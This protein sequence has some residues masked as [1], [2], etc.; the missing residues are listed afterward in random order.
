MSN[1]AITI[2]QTNNKKQ[3]FKHYKI[4]DK[5]L[6]V[7]N[8][9]I[10]NNT[11][12][13]IGYIP[14]NEFYSNSLYDIYGKRLVDIFNPFTS[15]KDTNTEYLINI[16]PNLKR[17]K[18]E[19]HAAKNMFLDLNKKNI[20]YLDISYYFRNKITVP[21]AIE[22]YD[23]HLKETEYIP[24]SRI[25]NKTNSSYWYKVSKR[26]DMESAILFKDAKVLSV[27]SNIVVL[28]CRFPYQWEINY[29]SAIL[30]NIRYMNSNNPGTF[31]LLYGK[32]K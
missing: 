22:L 6:P 14:D 24:V 29:T 1:Y 9:N 7:V 28:K 15:T 27:I 26:K 32:D 4:I 11:P 8:V 2:R 16:N 18:K 3:P 30:E 12:V 10:D 31:Y 5:E 25:M 13:K 21:K 19:L 20:R 23:Y 17:I